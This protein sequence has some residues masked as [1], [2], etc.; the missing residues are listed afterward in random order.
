MGV[1]VSDAAARRI[2]RFS[3]TL[4][5]VVAVGALLG[6]A[7][8]VAS[9]VAR[10]NARGDRTPW[11]NDEVVHAEREGDVWSS[12][13]SALVT[14]PEELLGRPARIT[15]AERRESLGLYMLDDEGLPVYLGSAFDWEPTVIPVYDDRELWVVGGGRWQLTLEPAE[16]QPL[17]SG[18]HGVGDVLFHY[19]GDA[20][21]ATISWTGE[22][23]LYLDAIGESGLESLVSERSDGAAGSRRVAWQP[24]EYVLFTISS[25]GELEWTIHLDEEVAP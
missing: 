19:R 12:D 8:T 18:D 4:A 14:L 11:Q 16:A 10:E 24:S 22:G 9:S 15:M 21:T 23:S 5:I 13:G 7:V 17:V 2:R 6:G 1:T 3:I 25:Y 20:T